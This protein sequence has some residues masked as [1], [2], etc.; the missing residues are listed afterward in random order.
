MN[1][2]KKNN[3]F[4]GI[5]NATPEY[6]QKMIDLGFQLVTIGSDQRYMSAGAKSAISKLKSIKSEEESK[7]Y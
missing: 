3:I 4:A 2:A 6:A 5:H 7:V 1:H